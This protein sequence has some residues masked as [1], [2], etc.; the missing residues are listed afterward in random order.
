M[1]N[2]HIFGWSQYAWLKGFDI[3]NLH[4]HVGM[5]V[6]HCKLQRSLRKGNRLME[7]N[8]Q[9]GYGM[10]EHSR[11][12]LTGWG[13]GAVVLSPRDLSADQLQRLAANIGEES[14]GGRILLDPQFYLPHASHHRLCAHDY[15]PE[16]YE[17]GTFWNGPQLEVLISKLIALNHSLGC[18][19]FVLPGLLASKIDEDWL[20][21]QRSFLEES[22][23]QGTDLPI[24][25]TIALSAEAIKDGSQIGLLLENASE[26]TADGYYLV[27]Q[28]PNGDYLCDDPT[29]MANVLDIVAGLRLLNAQVVVGYC[30]HQMLIASAA[31]ATAICSGTW[32]NVRS[33]P[34]EKF[35]TVYED[36]IRQRS[37]WYYCPQALSEYKIPYLDVAAQQGILNQMAPPPDLDGGYASKLFTAALPSNADF[38][39]QAAFR[40]YLHALQVQTSRA[41]FDS[42]DETIARHMELLAI[43]EDR[44][45][46]FSQRGVRGQNREFDQDIIDASRAALAILQNNRGPILRREWNNL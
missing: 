4:F 23:N 30:N 2:T 26:R 3:M 28:H 37:K 16:E 20:N 44:V 42:F 22:S 1:S 38:S 29:W 46:F 14:P 35:E 17:T 33:F 5:Q 19:A 21:I 11:Q 39:E 10:M 12:L 32:M 9:F 6:S 31:K 27:C 13:T 24:Y 8:L 40:H 36:E 7:F 34:P 18:D 45:Q 43:A 25:A 41:E 15:W